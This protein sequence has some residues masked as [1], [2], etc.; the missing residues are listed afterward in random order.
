MTFDLDRYKQVCTR[1]DHAD[2]DLTAAFRARPLSPE[3]LRCLRYMHDVEHHTTCYLR[4]LLNTRAHSDPDVTAFLTMWN[5]EEHWHG[6]A[7]AEVLRAHGEPGGAPRVAAMRQRLGAGVTAS[8]LLWMAFSSVSRHFLA[9]HMTFG[10]INEWTTQGAYARL[11]TLAGNDV[12]SELLRRIMR[13]EGRHIDYYLSQARRLLADAPGAR[14][15]TRRVV[16][17]AWSPVGEKIMPRSET[18]HV[19]RTLFGDEPGRA[20][21]ARIDRRIDALPGLDGLGLMNRA[22]RRYGGAGAA[23]AGME[24][25]YAVV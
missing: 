20:V 14:R 11:G 16:R 18:A 1:L 19:I 15:A 10:V 2:L 13:Q 12:L 24:P 17:M 6:E 23:T 9:V 7:L 22:L 5:Y 8:P 3:L 4:N 21:A 25:A